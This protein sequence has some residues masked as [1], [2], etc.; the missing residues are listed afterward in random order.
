LA[1]GHQIQWNPSLADQFSSS[2]TWME[3]SVETCLSITEQWSQEGRNVRVWNICVIWVNSGVRVEWVF[4]P[5][6]HLVAV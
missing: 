5:C 4:H 6:G 1:T 2:L 3:V